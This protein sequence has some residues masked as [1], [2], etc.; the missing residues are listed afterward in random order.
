MIN[1]LSYFL[2]FFSNL[3]I[4]FLVPDLKAQTFLAIYSLSSLIIGPLSFIFFS[5]FIKEIFKLKI[6][7]ILINFLLIFLI[8][9][10]GYLYFIY[11][12]NIFFCDLLSS[13]NQSQKLNFLFKFIL[14]VSVILL[15]LEIF[16]FN[17]LICFRVI[18][19]SILIIYLLFNN[20]KYITLD[21]QRPYYYQLITNLNYFGV[22]FVLTIFLEGYILKVIY[23]ILQTSQSAIL[24]LYDLKI[25][26]IIDDKN[27]NLIF[28]IVTILIFLIPLIFLFF[29]VSK[30]IIILY[31]FSF[32]I[33]FLVKYKFLNYEK[34]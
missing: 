28:K 16:S 19:C 10:D 29:K 11:T 17:T 21:I 23:I 22:L 14:A 15:I 4:I 32:G 31:Y 26:K 18:I 13:Q 1:L 33:L 27:F 6:V 20:N 34:N 30:M 25:R 2:Y 24:K 5:K 9:S 8:Q 12:L 7:I 3:I